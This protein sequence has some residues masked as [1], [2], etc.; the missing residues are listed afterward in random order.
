MRGTVPTR[1][2]CLDGIRRQCRGKFKELIMRVNDPV[3]VLYLSLMSR[4]QKTAPL[5]R[6][7]GFLD[8]EPAQNTQI[9]RLIYV[10]QKIAAGNVERV[11]SMLARYSRRSD[12]ESYISKNSSWMERPSPLGDGWFFEGCTSLVQKQDIVGNLSKLGLSGAFVQAVDDFIANK[13]I[14]QYFPTEAE[15][16]LMLAKIQ[17]QEGYLEE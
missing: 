12:G 14:E 11:Y 5:D 10:L 4:W 6:H 9:T 16:Q 2:G 1:W 13:P 3:E 17:A 8:G 15:E 7:A